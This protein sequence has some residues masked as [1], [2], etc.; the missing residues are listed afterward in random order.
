MNKY[1]VPV[2][3]LV[4]AQ[5]WNH[6]YTANSIADCQDQ[7]MLEFSDIYNENFLDF[8]EFLDIMDRKY[9]YAIGEITDIETL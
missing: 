3:N 5:V 6:V 7:M 2:C 4:D 8:H 1:I 9:D